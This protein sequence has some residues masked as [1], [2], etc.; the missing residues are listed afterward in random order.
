MNS[1][2][3]HKVAK[4]RDLEVALF[5]LV[6]HS[7]DEVLEESTAYLECPV[8]E[9]MRPVWRCLRMCGWLLSACTL[10][11]CAMETVGDGGTRW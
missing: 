5:V 6:S 10:L 9:T 1:K 7:M 3:L 2:R 8:R 11:M 4:E